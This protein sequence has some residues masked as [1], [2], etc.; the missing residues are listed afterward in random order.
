MSGRVRFVKGSGFEMKCGS[1][2]LY[3]ALEEDEW[4]P[5][6]GLTRCA[7]CWR[8]Y[9]RLHEEGRRGDEITNALKNQ[10]ARMRYAFDRERRLAATRAWKQANRER[11]AAYNKAYRESH[12]EELRAKRQVYEAECGDVIR[13]KKRLAYVEKKV[14]A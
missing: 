1:C 14:A 13:M 3:V 9:H 10:N 12:R 4:R 2:G 8:E 6:A 11:I 7:S 5:K